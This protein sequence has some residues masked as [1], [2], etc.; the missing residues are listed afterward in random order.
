MHPIVNRLLLKVRQ[1]LV[2]TLIT[3]TL[4]F[5]PIVGS[6]PASAA[7]AFPFG[8]NSA[9]Q[10]ANATEPTIDRRVI[11]GIQDKAEDLGDDAERDIG[12]TG[13]KNIRELPEN[14][15]DTAK[16]VIKQRTGNDP[17]MQPGSNSRE[18][19]HK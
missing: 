5:T 19:Q 14:I 13:L 8:D 2:V 18:M 10:P 3:A 12:V 7:L 11:K 16:M 15:P 9:D 4:L 6:S 1:V 17:N